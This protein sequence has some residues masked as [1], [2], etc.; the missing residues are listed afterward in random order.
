MTTSDLLSAMYALP[1]SALKAQ[2]TKLMQKLHTS[3]ASATT[4]TSAPSARSC[5]VSARTSSSWSDPYLH[6]VYWLMINSDGRFLSG[7]SGNILQWAASADEVPPE[8]RFTDYY[9]VKNRWLAIRS[10][11]QMD[12]EGLAIQPVDFYAHRSTPHL[13]AAAND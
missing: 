3:C 11:V 7:I 6:R 5:S 8:L 10:W 12:D 13:W 4:G 2:S 9:A 1:S